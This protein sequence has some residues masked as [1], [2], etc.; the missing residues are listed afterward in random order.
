MKRKSC[1]SVE[2][3]SEKPAKMAR[4]TEKDKKYDRQLRL[5]GD[6][7]QKKL[8]TAKVCL[9]NATALG[10]EILKNLVLPGVGSFSVVDKHKICD[11]DIGNNFF[12]S[13]KY[14]GKSRAQC[15]VE[16]LQELNPDVSGN[17]IE[18]DPS[19][20][21]TNNP[22]F[23]KEF[24]VVIATGLVERTRLKISSCLW[25]AGIPLLLCSAYGMI[26]MMRLVVQ[27]HTVVE[28]HPDNAFEDLRLDKPF[29]RLQAFSD[30]LELTSMSKLEHS[31]TPYVVLLLKYLQKWKQTHE[32]KTPQNYKEKCSFKDT[33]RQGILV[34]ENG[35]PEE[36]DNFEEALKAVNTSLN[37]TRIPGT[38]QEILNDSHCETITPSSSAFW[39]LCRALKEFVNETGNLPL[40]GSIPDMTADSKRFI[41]LQNC[42]HEKAL[43]DIQNIS[44]KLRA[45]LSSI[46]KKSNFIED[47]EIRL[48]CKN[49]AFLRVIRCS[50]L[51]E[52]YKTFPQC[53]DGLIDEPDNDVIFYVL[54]RAV[55]KFYSSFDRY[56]GEVDEDV[57]GDCERLQACVTD[58]FKEWGVHCGIKDDYIKEMCR[59]GAC[60]LHPV[61]AFMGGAA[62]H[63]AIKL[64]THQYVP[65][66]DCY[67]YNAM[68]G[69]SVTMKF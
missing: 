21:A 24:T 9:I 15:A 40:R 3:Q 69:S 7:G 43:E 22:D 27:E 1:E 16:L 35:A 57:E 8:E 13:N 14:V 18:E 47:D 5:W 50:S 55:D 65:F 56:P 2:K 34:K 59:Y 58:L 25:E 19:D 6:H 38:I 11:K 30:S 68:T 54:L 20:L 44:E 60:E 66:N 51:C 37:T 31:H 4:A 45:I 64:I 26:G 63:E 67:I 42:Y 39:I 49:S 53:L 61:A 32:G 36:E 17:F 41:Q 10:T 62:A 23:F 29:P 52:E 48:F 33:L 46:G 12:L 28:S